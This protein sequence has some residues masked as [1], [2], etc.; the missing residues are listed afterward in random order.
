MICPEPRELLRLT[1]GGVTPER[2]TELRH[3]IESCAICHGHETEFS[4]VIERVAEVAPEYE[5]ATR[6]QR[7]LSA[8]DREP[9]KK[10]FVNLRWGWTGGL[11][12]AAAALLLVVIPTT[13]EEGEDGFTAR[14]GAETGAQWVGIELFRLT[15][16]DAKPQRVNKSIAVG[17]RLLVSYTNLDPS[18]FGHLTVLVRDATGKI[19]WLHPGQPKDGGP[20]SLTVATKVRDREIPEAVRLRL[21]PGRA[22]V[23]AVFAKLS[24]GQRALEDWLRG[25]QDEGRA[26]PAEG[27]EV[28]FIDVE[29][30]GGG[31]PE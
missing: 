26:G 2:A 5:S 12:M 8:L 15:D 11:A 31:K 18:G 1:D 13:Q 28:H 17:N 7:I 20:T 19:H 6:R 30:T 21:A 14:S 10:P 9:E 24:L 27:T 4:E 23:A 3:H 16:S 22:L 29:V 25:V